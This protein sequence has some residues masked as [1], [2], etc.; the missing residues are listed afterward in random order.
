MFFCFVWQAS[1]WPCLSAGIFYFGTFDGFDFQG[2][3]HSA[4]WVSFPSGEHFIIKQLFI[5][6]SCRWVLGSEVVLV[7]GSLSSQVSLL[8]C[9]L[10]FIFSAKIP[11]ITGFQCDLSTCLPIVII[12]LHSP[13]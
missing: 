13:K 1:R 10:L 8:C 6:F 9:A 5:G 7:A 12:N 3:F 2:V 11:S 4:V